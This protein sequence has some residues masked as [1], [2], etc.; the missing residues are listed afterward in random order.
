MKVL[1]KYYSHCTI[2]Q[3]KMLRTWKLK[4]TILYG[5]PIADQFANSSEAELLL[6]H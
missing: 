1:Y 4:Y 3:M 2:T 5:F 6:R